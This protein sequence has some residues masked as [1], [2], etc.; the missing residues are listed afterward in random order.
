M[1]SPER[2]QVWENIVAALNSPQQPKFSLTA[3]QELFEIG[4]QVSLHF[5][6][7]TKAARRR[8]SLHNEIIQVLKNNEFAIVDY[9]IFIPYKMQITDVFECPNKTVTRQSSSQRKSR[10]P[11]GKLHCLNF[12]FP[13]ENETLGPVC[14]GYEAS[15]SSVSLSMLKVPIKNSGLLVGSQDG[16][17]EN[18]TVRRK[19]RAS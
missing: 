17:E 3:G 1:R 2:G 7:K 8:E 12:V 10:R 11:S 14:L 9:T 6:T 18:S 19:L 16:D 13:A 15:S 5:K 4:I